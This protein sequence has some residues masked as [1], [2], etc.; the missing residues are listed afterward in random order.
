V[1]R[2]WRARVLMAAALGSTL[3]GAIP[4]ARA[5]S[6]V[7]ITPDRRLAL[8]SKDV[9]DQRWAIA[10]DAATGVVT[11]NVFFP[12]GGEPAFVWCERTDS[13]G[14]L[15]ETLLFSCFGAERCDSSPCTAGEWSL[16]AD[17][18]LPASF[19]A[20]PDGGTPQDP[21]PTEDAALFSYL[22]SG[23]YRDFAAESGVHPSAGPHGN[24][25]RSFVNEVLDRSLAEGSLSHP[26]GAAAVKELYAGDGTTLTGWA[27][28]VKI[29][30]DSAGGDGWYWYE[31][32][33]TTDGSRP[34]SGAG[35]PICT[36][37]HAEGI[38]YVRIPYPLQ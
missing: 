9:G 34:I 3:L 16:I 26:V 8:V 5:Q 6:G 37:C 20:P 22:Q 18:D 4:T 24:G 27:V 19:L 15:A 25:V 36:G 13:G 2:G 14:A 21:V 33:S 28:E 30:S 7:Q 11:G 17:V 38:D 10:Y 31:V 32:F 1:T 35:N 23:R 12:D 29:Q